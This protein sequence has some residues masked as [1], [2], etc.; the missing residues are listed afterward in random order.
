MSFLGV[1]SIRSGSARES[2]AILEGCF[3]SIL[4]AAGIRLRYALFARRAGR[5]A[6]IDESDV[7][8]SFQN[9]AILGLV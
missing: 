5:L 6:G 1:L 2:G 7:Q 3:D 9:R 4:S 8:R